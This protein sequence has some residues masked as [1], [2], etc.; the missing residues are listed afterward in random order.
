MLLIF[1]PV[2]SKPWK[3]TS[4]ECGFYRPSNMPADHHKK[5]FYENSIEQTQNKKPPL[6]IV[7][8]SMPV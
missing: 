8:C 7:A 3:G 2:K 6:D 4:R 5:K 1:P